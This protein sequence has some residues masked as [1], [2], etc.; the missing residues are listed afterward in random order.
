[1]VPVSPSPFHGREE[2]SFSKGPVRRDLQRLGDEGLTKGPVRVHETLC[3]PGR[4]GKTERELVSSPMGILDSL[5]FYLHEVSLG[6][7]T[8]SL[9]K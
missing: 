9:P 4:F 5:T 1:M 2:C 8:F 7:R 6:E 3:H